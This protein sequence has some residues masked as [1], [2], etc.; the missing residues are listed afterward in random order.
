MGQLSAGQM[1][2]DQAAL[3]NKEAEILAQEQM[4]TQLAAMAV[5][6]EAL[7]GRSLGALQSAASV[8][9]NHTSRLAQQ[10]TSIDAL[11]AMMTG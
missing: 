6:S 10:Q 4:N 8:I 5:Q 1:A 9:S 7:H 3:A 11:Q 2:A